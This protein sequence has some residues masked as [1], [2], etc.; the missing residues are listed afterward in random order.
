MPGA[1]GFGPNPAAVRRPAASSGPTPR[2]L[3][4]RPLEPRFRPRSGSRLI[5]GGEVTS[6]GAHGPG[7][8]SREVCG[9]RRGQ[10]ETVNAMPGQLLADRQRHRIIVPFLIRDGEHDV[11]QQPG[12]ATCPATMEPRSWFGHG[13][14]VARPGGKWQ[15]TTASSLGRDA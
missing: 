1:P 4:S 14:A 15:D 13:Q 5:M 10:G 6:G 12:R 2:R 3:F 11:S 7:V 9:P 8:G